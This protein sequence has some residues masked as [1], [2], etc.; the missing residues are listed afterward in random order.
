MEN[1]NK[2]QTCGSGSEVNTKIKYNMIKGEFQNK[3]KQY[4]WIREDYN[5]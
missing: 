2:N 5:T 1:D 3:S 4:G